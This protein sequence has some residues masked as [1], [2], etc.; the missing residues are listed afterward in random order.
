[1]SRVEAERLL[2]W[3]LQTDRGGVLARRP[4]PLPL[5][6][7]EQFEELL[8]RRERRE[9]LQYLTGT[10]EFLGLGF[11]VDRRV[12]IP[13]PETEGVVEH[14]L[15]VETGARARVL[16][17]GTGS[18]CIAVTLGVRRPE[19][20]VVAID[21]GEEPLE[22]ALANARRHGVESRV[23]FSLADLAALPGD[24]AGTFDLI[25]SNPPYVSE[26]EWSTLAP[27]VRD[28]EPKGALV[29]GPSGLEAYQALAPEAFRV[30]RPGG[31]LVLELGYR[32]EAGARAAVDA[33]GFTGTEVHPD[34]RSIPRTLIAQKQGHSPFRPQMG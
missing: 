5:Q 16:D 30:L 2:A 6:T 26:D 24:L 19:W 9:P 12:L 28:H 29:P 17:V 20:T 8:R 34:L 3:V 7:A 15:A 10:V 25:V 14:A 18:G 23:E 4:D 33:A 27:E 32:S 31:A 1:M 21:T 11:A 22:V 13:R